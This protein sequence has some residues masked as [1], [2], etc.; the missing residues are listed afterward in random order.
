M[1]T[2]LISAALLPPGAEERRGNAS[3][4][5]PLILCSCET[6]PEK[7]LRRPRLPFWVPA[8]HKMAALLTD[9]MAAALQSCTIDTPCCAGLPTTRDAYGDSGKWIF[10]GMAGSHPLTSLGEFAGG[11]TGMCSLHQGLSDYDPFLMFHGSIINNRWTD[12][13]GQQ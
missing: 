6:A 12:G 7:H 4:L 1:A 2:P 3:V 13:N 11:T 5:V 10:R 8:R 9:K